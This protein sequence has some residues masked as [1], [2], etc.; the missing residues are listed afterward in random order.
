MK[1][2]TGTKLPAQFQ[3]TKEFEELFELI[4]RTNKNLF[5]TGKAGSGKSTL[6]EYFR[7]NTK[8]NHAILAPTGITAIKAKGKTVHSFFKFPP[9]FVSKKDVKILRD[10]DL[11]KRL[12][13]L[14]I[15]ESS[16]LRADIFDAI[17]LSLKIN[18]GNKK[19][20]GGVQ[21]I[22]FGDLLQLPPVV[23]SNDREVMEKFYPKGEFF[24]NSNS[25]PSGNFV[26]YELSKIFRQTEKSFIDILN[27]I[28]IAKITDKELSILN[29]RILDNQTEIKKGTIILSP[30]N[31]KV[32]SINNENLEKLKGELYE[33]DASITGNYKESEYPVAKKLYL[34]V[35]AQVMITKNDTSQP[36]KWVNGTLGI[37]ESLEGE[38]IKIKINGRV[39]YLG[40]TKWEKIDYRL[41]G[42]NINPIPVATF[43]QYPLKLAWAATIHKCQ[44]QTFDKVAIDLD[45]GSFEHGQTYVALSR[46]KT[47]EGINLFKEISQSDLI[48]N[49]KVFDFLG[50]KIE[51]KYIKEIR[52]D[53]KIIKLSNYKPLN[54][55]KKYS[56]INLKVNWTDEKDK[57]LKMLYKK[58]LPESALAG[59][60]KTSIKEI[61]NRIS[62]FV[63]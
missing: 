32:D 8:K 16:M 36:Q 50:K 48:F 33:F 14:L 28:R 60:F 44:G 55:E 12:D 47:I 34:K 42:N 49:K 51:K 3:L 30:R 24:F 59:I 29:K 2:D 20:F 18:R 23:S 37:I 27:K 11:I 39:H 10:R 13:T 31:H 17:D 53:R 35:G 40:K 21:L 56:N 38:K 25:F 57:K 6:L 1:L 7:Q 58:N 62:S 26:T 54:E 63:K 5:I 52:K 61:R 43:I 19:P 15:D 41:K 45:T 22:L 4:E 9:R 46:A